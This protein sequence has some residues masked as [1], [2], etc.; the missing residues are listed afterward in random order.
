L[1]LLPQ[2]PINSRDALDLLLAELRPK[3]HR[4]CARMTGSVVDGE[5]VVQEAFLKAIVAFQE[6]ILISAP[7]SWL[8]GIAH[9]AAL[10]FLRRR[11]R[12]DAKQTHEGLDMIVDPVA[13]A[14][15][16]EA[17]TASLRTFMRLPVAQ[18]SAVILMDVFG[19]SLGEIAGITGLTVP[20]LKAS[21][22]RGRARLRELA[23]EPDDA[24]LPHLEEEERLR[25]SIYI[26]RFNARDFDAVRTMLADDVKLELVN[27]T[28]MNG[29][30]EVGRYFHNYSA[31]ENWRL[32]IGHVDRRPAVLVCDPR[33]PSQGWTG[34]V[35]LEWADDRIV[36][37]RDFRHAA[38]V[39]ESAELLTLDDHQSALLRR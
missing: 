39:V 14:D 38:Y 21:L 20:A 8:F 17:T 9:N 13:A 33:S 6:P 22:H 37:I 24:A 25:L 29:L 4:Y 30:R 10:D 36:G 26:E 11:T 18:R 5:D 2:G 12:M 7:G 15:S 31:V 16:R 3:L 27:R 23:D 34:F 1:N 28:R 32:S 19:Y 35:L